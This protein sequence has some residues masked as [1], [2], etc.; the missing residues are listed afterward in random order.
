MSGSS[1]IV[2]VVIR[3]YRLGTTND[4]ILSCL[5]P[6]ELF[7]LSA[8]GSVCREAVAA[9]LKR[10]YR[11]ELFL[12]PFFTVAQY[13]SFQ[14]LQAQ[15]GALISGLAALQFIDRTSYGLTDLDVYVNHHHVREVHD[16]LIS[17]G[18][19]YQ[20]E[21]RESFDAFKTRLDGVFAL[22]LSFATSNLSASYSG[23][24]VFA[25]LHYYKDSKTKI[26]VVTTLFCPFQV[27]LG[28]H[29]SKCVHFA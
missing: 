25:V 2:V 9:F 22:T 14:R 15:T 28:F 16:F 7:K 23:R 8:T 10:A 18:Y 5:S 29:S 1:F 12:L 21:E 3:I 24:G 13:F 6:G 26:D 4:F 19:I 11:P 27:I 17:I 20:E